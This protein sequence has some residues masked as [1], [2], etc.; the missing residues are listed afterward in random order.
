VFLVV[1]VL[2]LG[3][4]AL[5]GSLAKLDGQTPLPGLSA[6]VLVERDGQGVPTISATN[7]LDLARAVGFLHGQERF[8]QMDLTRRS[9]A[10]ELSE[11]LG[12]GQLDDDRSTRR[13][14]LRATAEKALALLR[15][16]ER[17]LLAAYAEGVN[18]GVT[19]LT[20]R[21]PEYLLLRQKPHPWRPEDSV[22]VL[23]SMG[24]QLS[25]PWAAQEPNLA[26][27]RQALSPAA[28]EFYGR[29]DTAY[30][31]ALDDTKLPAPRLPTPEEFNARTAPTNQ[32]AAAAAREDALMPGSNGWAIG[33]KRTTTGA[34]M[35]ANDMHLGL[36]LPNTWYRAQFIWR[37]AAGA[38]RRCIG[39]TLPGTPAMV[40]GSNGRVAWAFTA[41][42]LDVSDQVL[43]ETDPT[44]PD[45]CRVGDYW[46]PFE[47]ISEEIKVA[48]G[49]NVVARIQWSSWGPVGTNILGQRVAFCWA[50]DFP[51]AAN[52][53]SLAFELAGS[54]KE[55]LASAP[56][57]GLPW[58]NV[59][60]ADRDG[61]VGWTLSGHFPKRVGFD[62]RTPVSWAD[63]THRW[64]GWVEGAEMPVVF[65]PPTS[66]VW[67]ANNRHL[68]SASY[69]RIM[70]GD[71]TD[72]GAR[73]TQ[74][75]D[76]LRVLTNA[77]SADLLAI[78]LDDRALFVQPWQRLLLTTLDAATNQNRFAEARGLVAD[79]G[80]HAAVSSVGYRLVRDFRQQVVQ[81]LMEP[82]IACCRAANPHFEYVP[83]HYEGV[84]WDLL[85]ER[86]PHLLPLAF[87]NYDELLVDA[88]RKTLKQVP[89]G[90]PL[91][92]YTWGDANRVQV[93]HPFGKA[94]SVLSHWLD[95]PERQ[96][97]GD[98][99]MPRVQGRDFGASERMV[100]SP[101][102][103]A[104]G[105]FHMPGG[106][107]GH[108]LSPFYAA[109]H[110]DWE[111]GRLTP[112]LPGVTEH[113]LLLR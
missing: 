83:G 36:G 27:A 29:S 47:T 90:R 106:Q 66:A 75:R 34:G 55:L 68:G 45:A 67:S 14:R 54:T 72:H 88:A 57:C 98:H 3:W 84:A 81:A 26:I 71:D 93:R 15:P 77:R 19:A 89:A 17:A 40:A 33:G 74:I 50:M 23:H 73:A 25:D 99:N 22:L 65:N 60:A 48:G 12:Q 85:K 4:A 104:E 64:D 7:R 86:P 105:I 94:I 42:Q 108:F 44:H 101:G 53:G 79:W 112:L 69:Q 97:P 5:R 32:Q 63:G 11:L 91:A 70:G 110:Q 56:G 82:A 43:L 30:P 2:G 35:V 39:V 18:A 95:L 9:A 78:Q 61:E 92:T 51:E 76:Q 87:T 49:S 31:A 1:A 107:S 38:E 103:E 80:A 58:V 62:G 10:G 46:K 6:P 59:M 109:G 13:L 16:E 52:F 20:I 8:F 37:D 111:E 102:H 28:F 96:L 100:V 21:P 41:A 113:R 24:L